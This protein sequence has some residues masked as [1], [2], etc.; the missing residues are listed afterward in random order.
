MHSSMKRGALL[1]LTAQRCAIVVLVA[2]ATPLGCLYSPNPDPTGPLDSCAGNSDCPGQQCG[3]V[4]EG[5]TC[6]WNGMRYVGVDDKHPYVTAPSN[7]NVIATL[8][9][10]N[11]VYY[12]YCTDKGVSQCNSANDCPPKHVCGVVVGAA[13]PVLQCYAWPAASVNVMDSCATATCS[14]STV[15]TMLF[16]FN[17]QHILTNRFYCLK[18][19]S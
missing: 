8:C 1:G 10:D 16:W 2:L 4:A 12:P 14:N 15:C 19:P 13:N 9:V 17:D 3:G 7:Q 6:T 5:S 11:Q 18:P